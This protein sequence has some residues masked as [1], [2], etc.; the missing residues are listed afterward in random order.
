[1]FE[2]DASDKSLYWIETEKHREHDC[3]VQGFDYNP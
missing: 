1:M 2:F 3:K